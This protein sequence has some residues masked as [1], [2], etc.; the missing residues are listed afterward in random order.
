[1]V[2]S[3]PYASVPSTIIEKPTW[4][5]RIIGRSA[6]T[7]P[8]I[9]DI[10]KSAA[11]FPRS[12]MTYVSDTSFTCPVIIRAGRTRNGAIFRNAHIP[13]IVILISGTTID[14]VIFT[15]RY[16][17]LF[18]NQETGEGGLTRNKTRNF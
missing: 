18:L 17:E 12:G 16:N 7:Q 15:N 6:A 2:F 9:P 13:L 4:A 10:I 14:V 11:T 8:R 1:M 3:I 5:F